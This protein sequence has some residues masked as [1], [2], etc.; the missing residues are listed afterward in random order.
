MISKK[1]GQILTYL[2]NGI[3]KENIIKKLHEFFGYKT[4]EIKQIFK[5]LQKKG[6]I[7]EIK[8]EIPEMQFFIISAK[9][10]K[11]MLDDEVIYVLEQSSK[12]KTFKEFL[13]T[14]NASE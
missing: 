7:E 9:V 13:K 3:R 10:T 11:N 12:F 5:K 8:G 6:L 14:K 4:Q 2:K 1:E